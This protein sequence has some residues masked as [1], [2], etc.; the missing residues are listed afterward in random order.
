VPKRAVYEAEINTLGIIGNQV[1]HPK[2]HGGPT[3]AL[4]L[5]SL[6]KIL[7]LQAE[8]HPIFPGSVGENLTV[9]QLDWSLVMPG[10]RL[11]LGDA[12]IIEV[13]RYTTPC[14]TIVASFADKNSNRILQKTHEGWARVYAKVVQTGKIKVGDAIVLEK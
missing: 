5:Y 7:A 3:A 14:N 4:C 12:V 13:T 10:A 8:G 1:A 2:I 9:A 11:R 6:E